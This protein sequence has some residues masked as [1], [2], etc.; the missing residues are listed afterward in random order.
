MATERD[1]SMSPP[2]G[3][4]DRAWRSPDRDVSRLGSL[5]TEQRNPRSSDIDTMTALELVDLLNSEDSTV[6]AAVGLAREEIARAVEL[7]VERFR[8]GGRLIYAGAGTSG[9]LGVLDAAECPP[10]FGTDPSMV[11]GL[12]AGGRDALVRAQEG[13]ED[14]AESGAAAVRELGVSCDDVVVG[15]ATSGVTPY[16]LGALGEAGGAGAATVFVCCV[17]D[18]DMPVPVDVTIS[19][20]VG[21]EVVTG[22]TRLKAGTATKLVLNSITTS[23]MVLLGKTYGNLM[24]D[25]TATCDKLRDRAC[26]IVMETTGVGRDE[27]ARVIE[28][29]E[30]SVKAAIVMQKTGASLEEALRLID[31]AAGFVREALRRHS[32]GE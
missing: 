14:V 20:L 2:S 6:P 21:P 32:E 17:P 22:S 7:V 3:R 4:G 19:P 24:V 5:L 28:R 27:A 16:V 25:L 13:A 12:I 18:P 29:A 15:I 9:R 30:G 23:A 31:A 1:D 8:R 26:R 11:R 10:T